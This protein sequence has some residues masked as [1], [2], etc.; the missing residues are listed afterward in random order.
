MATYCNAAGAIEQALRGVATDF[1]RVDRALWE[2]SLTNGVVVRARVRVS[3]PW[4]EVSAPLP[5]AARVGVDTESWLRFNASL[6]GPVRAVCGLRTAPIDLRADLNIE[7]EPDLVERVASV[8]AEIGAVHHRCQSECG[9]AALPL[10]ACPASGGIDDLARLC[11]E[12]GWPVARGSTG[13]LRVD[14]DAGIG[15]FTAHLEAVDSTAFRALVELTDLAAYSSSSRH[16]V[17][18]LLLAIGAFVHSV[19]GVFVERGGAELAA[20]GAA[21]P[22]PRSVLA[23]DRS[24]SALAVACGLVGREV[25]A[26]RDE[27]LSRAYVERWD[28]GHLFGVGVVNSNVTTEEDTCLQQL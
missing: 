18:R 19:K 22:W 17:A 12:A 10:A 27:G 8:C 28:Q 9:Q 15:V 14:L 16:A 2:F 24:L 1:T 5:E 21:V 4:L 23:L 20:L 6:D 11:A 3:D 25:P 13:R 7:E 26:L